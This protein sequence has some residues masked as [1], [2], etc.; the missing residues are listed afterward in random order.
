MVGAWFSHW[1][2]R[3]MRP[4]WPVRGLYRPHAWHSVAQSISISWYSCSWNIMLMSPRQFTVCWSLAVLCNIYKV[5]TNWWPRVTLHA[6]TVSHTTCVQR[7]LHCHLSTVR[8]FERDTLTIPCG[9]V[10]KPPYWKGRPYT[11]NSLGTVATPH[12]PS[13]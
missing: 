10:F 9:K 12:T 4:V 11:G 3:P 13:P 7:H 1:T 5:T 6:A 8:D 2:V